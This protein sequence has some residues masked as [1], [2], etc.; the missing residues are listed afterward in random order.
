MAT[1]AE[2][3]TK[4]A[5]YDSGKRSSADILNE[6]MTSYGVPEIRSRVAGLRTT[7]G[8]TEAALNAV[9]PSVTGRTSRS[10]VT[11]AQRQRIVAN[12]RQPLAQQYSS[13]SGALTTES[14]N[15]NDQQSAAKLLAEQKI[16]DYTTGRNALQ[17]QYDIAYTAE[18]N[19]KAQE[20]ARQQAAE[21][22]RQYDLSL[23]EQKR[24]ANI[25]A[26]SARSS[27]E[28]STPTKSQFLVSAF[29]GY[30]PKQANGY[31]EKEVIPALMANYNITKD[32]AAK[33]AYRYR[34]QNYGE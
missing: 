32:E 12:E 24:Q 18:Q 16:N 33:L 29:S 19:A 3:A 28:G 6:A 13:Q 9:D 34:K 26:S 2:L 10:L 23:A 30:D 17:S 5:A 20:M 22:R 4:L 21:Q 14:A 15:L 1:A 11:E 8:N 25:S 7:L 27:R 31:T